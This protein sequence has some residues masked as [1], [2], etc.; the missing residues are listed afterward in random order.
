MNHFYQWRCMRK[1]PLK[2]LVST[3]AVLLILAGASCVQLP[4]LVDTS[5]TPSPPGIQNTP[6]TEKKTETNPHLEIFPTQGEPGSEV[7]LNLSGYPAQAKL[8]LG[9]GL[10]D[11]EFEVVTTLT[12]DQS[13][14]IE[15]TVQ[16][17]SHAS[18][19][20]VWVFVSYNPKTD[21]KIISDEFKVISGPQP[22][23]RVSPTIP[24]MGEILDVKLSNYPPQQE[25]EIGIG[26]VN[27]E[28]DILEI[29]K[30]DNEGNLH[31]QFKLPEYV[32][33]QDDWVVVASTENGE[34]KALSR[35][36]DIIEPGTAAIIVSPLTASA[37]NEVQI[38]L[39]NLPAETDVQLGIGRVN[40]EYD[41]LES[42][43]TDSE[44]SLTTTFT[45]PD[46]VD[47]SDQWVIVAVYQQGRE[48]LFSQTLQITE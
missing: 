41:L 13:G 6:I 47:T 11:S 34:H 8:D 22:A 21:R 46:F 19:G 36:L 35:T 18:P 14:K 7:K 31:T 20:E 30:T 23:L 44:G 42:A 3:A 16:V 10:A 25:I 2:L 29:V 15:S 1:D 37:G 27:S 4:A 17:P 43:Q 26:R 45:I 48:K 9:M 40:S 38:H 5:P 32:T 33:A 24:E 28:Y 12:T 39:R